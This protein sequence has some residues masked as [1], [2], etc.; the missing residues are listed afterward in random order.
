[1]KNLVLYVKEKLSRHETLSD[2]VL[3]YICVYMYICRR[4]Y[5]F[6]TCVYVEYICIYL[7]IFSSYYCFILRLFSCKGL[8]CRFFIILV[9]DPVCRVAVMFVHIIKISYGPMNGVSYLYAVSFFVI[10]QY[11]TL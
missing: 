10:N 5:S 4:I 8:M 3:V 2:L 6:F 1:M 11:P 7:Y 9:T